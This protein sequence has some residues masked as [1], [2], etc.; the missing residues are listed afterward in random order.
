[1]KAIK[2]TTIAAALI[3]AAALGSAFFF[4]SSFDFMDTA[5]TD[6][7]PDALIK[8]TVDNLYT[9]LNGMHRAMYIQYSRQDQGGEAS[10]NIN[11]ICW[12]KI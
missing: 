7:V 2:Y 11:Q 5:P 9:A 4:S 3:G 12:V 10:M 6:K 1:M 8:E